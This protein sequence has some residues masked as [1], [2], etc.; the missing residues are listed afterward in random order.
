MFAEFDSFNNLEVLDMSYNEIDNLVVPQELHNFTNLE[1]LTLS[2]SSLHISLLQSIASIFPSLKNLSMYGCEVNGVVR[3]QGFLHFKRLE[4]LDMGFAR[5][6]FNTSFLHIIGES[7]PSLK[8]LSLSNSSLSTDNL[9]YNRLNGS[10]PDLVDGLS[11]L[12]HLI[13]APNNL[14]GKVP[15]QLCRLNQLQLLD[16]SNNNLHGLIPPCFDNTTLHESYSNGSSLKPFE[17][18]F[19]VKNIY[20]YR[21]KKIL[22]IFEFT[23][24]NIAYTYQGRVVSY[25]SGLD[26]SCNKLIC[27]ISPQIG[28]LTRIQTLN[29]SHNDLIG[30]IPSTFSNLKHIESLD[31]SYNQLNGKIPLQLVEL[32]TLAVFSV[33]H[34]N[35]SGSGYGATV[36]PCHSYI[37]PLDALELVGFIGIQRLDATV[38]RYHSCTTGFPPSLMLKSSH[39][40]PFI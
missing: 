8:Y 2:G 16:L 14:E 38:A 33:A 39:F 37:Q 28:N 30:T 13:L 31:L 5:F 35:L 18:S 34:N 21:E 29:L 27:H 12:S 40:I 4:Y 9:S 3:G 19:L 36:V 32:N 23:T 15:V 7:M 17:T 11:Q 22:E 25:L 10:I 20:I 1:Y 6:V 26:L 24:K